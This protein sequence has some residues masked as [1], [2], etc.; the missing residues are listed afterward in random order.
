LCTIFG[1]ATFQQIMKEF[2]AKFDG[3]AVTI[4]DFLQTAA[5]VTKTNLDQFKLWYDLAGTPT[6]II[7]DAFTAD[8]NYTLK[9]KQTHQK[10]TKDFYI[11][12]TIGLISPDGTNAKTETLI[13]DKNE[14]IFSFPNIITKPIPS[15]ARNFSAPIKIEYSYTDDELLLL[16]CHDQDPINAWDASQQLLLNISQRLCDCVRVSQPCALPPILVDAFKTIINNPKID[17][18]LVVQMLQIPTEGFLLDSLPQNSIE[19]IHYVS[20]FLKLELAQALKNELLACYKNNNEIGHYGLDAISTGKRSLKNI[21][22]SY[23]MHLNTQEVFDVCLEQLDQANNMTDMLTCLTAIANS[24]YSKREQILEDHYQKWQ[25][26]PNLVNKWLALNATI[27]LLGTLQR[28]QKLTQHAA[29]N[30]KNPN[31]VYA[32]IRTFC[33]SNHINFHEASGAGYE[34]LTDQVL[35][36][37]KF[38]PQLA[39]AIVMPLTHGHKLDKKRQQLLQLQLARIS[40][41]PNLSKNVYEIISSAINAR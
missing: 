3:Q 22:L 27:K 39:A 12:L 40:Q 17:I 38:N 41:E 29:F 28:I 1:R 30:I 8:K 9:I 37:D 19:T 20:E 16:M 33:E 2:L 14:L 23:L 6:L 32:L 35:T 7:N 10:T 26:H 24:N 13:I 5:W 36:I 21:C 4:E 15:L 34:F 25:D 31:K 18:A 11:P